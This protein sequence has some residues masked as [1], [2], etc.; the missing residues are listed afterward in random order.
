MKINNAGIIIA[1]LVA[2]GVLLGALGRHP[3]G[4]YT[5]L[6]WVVC[7]VSAFAA[8]RATEFKK[9]GWAWAL[10]IVALIF[11][12]LVPV[13]LSRETWAFVDVTTAVLILV[14]VVAIDRH[15]PPP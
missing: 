11:N 12:P 10:A 14:S 7:G 8:F 6:R 13:H 3:Y 9:T 15:A 2:A 5:L 4:Y 1:K